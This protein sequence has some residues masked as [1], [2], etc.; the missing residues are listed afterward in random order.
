MKDE[1]HE[2]LLTIKVSH[3]FCITNKTGWVQIKAP[4]VF[5]SKK[6]IKIGFKIFGI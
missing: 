2:T 1:S 6:K 3:V 5:K 4:K